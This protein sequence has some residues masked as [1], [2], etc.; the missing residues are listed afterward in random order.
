MPQDVTDNRVLWELNAEGMTAV[1]GPPINAHRVSVGLTTVDDVRDHV[2][3]D[4]PWLAS[5]P[6]LDPGQRAAELKVV[7]TGAWSAPDARPLPA[8]LR[9]FLDAGPP[10][11][12]VGFGSI[13]LRAAGETARAAIEAIR[14]HGRRALVSRGWAELSLIDDGDDCFAV[15]EVNQQALFGKIAAVIHHGGA[16]T[17][18]AASRAGAPQVVVPQ[19][20]DQPYWAR[21]VAELGI[22]TAHDGPTVTVE[23]LSEALVIALAPQV[24]ACAATVAGSIRADGA[25]VAARLLLEDTG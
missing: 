1:F 5:D 21:R 13:P 24:R 12:H 14:A 10:P 9:A 11:V 23:S 25:T 18:T 16:G 15:D 4:R 2:S 7:Q 20:G 17:T 22:G 8:D 6:T 19:I 3:T